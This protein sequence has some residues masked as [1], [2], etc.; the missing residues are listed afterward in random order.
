MPRLTT[1]VRPL[2]P[3]RFPWLRR[4]QRV[5]Q[6]SWAQ[7]VFAAAQEI[8]L[9]NRAL[10][11]AAQALVTLVPLLI[12]VAAAYPVRGQGFAAWLVDGLGV[13]GA[14]ADTLR[15]LFSA[16]Q[17]VLSATSAFSVVAAAGF[18]LSFAT[19][20][21]TG[22]ERVWALSP[23]HWHAVWRRGAVLA[24][25]TGALFVDVHSASLLRHGWL[26]G[27]VRA[28]S[29]YLGAT[30]LCW[31]GQWLLLERRVAWRQLLPGAVLTALGLAALRTLCS[32][33][34]APLLAANAVTY[35]PI[36]AVLMVQTWLIGVGTVV[37]GGALLGRQWIEA[38]A[39]QEHTRYRRRLAR[40]PATA[41]GRP[42]GVPTRT[43]RADRPARRARPTRPSNP[44]RPWVRRPGRR[45][46]GHRTVPPGPA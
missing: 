31:W 9:T 42:G 4:A 16:P 27:T 1:P 11:F 17:R 34:L 2:E 6:R 37:F 5:W 21:Q 30:A 14:P 15:R 12:V 45:R 20:V 19:C 8:E 38:R 33:L 35:G 44:A 23:G 46:R 26:Q 29:T 10:S 28:L 13:T 43:D 24:A 32:L 39:P 7:S 22:Y 36:G 41:T 18:G 40:P 3:R 25:L